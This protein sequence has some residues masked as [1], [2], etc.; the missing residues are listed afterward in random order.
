MKRPR[1]AIRSR[2]SAAVFRNSNTG[3]NED[4]RPSTDRSPQ[5]G[6]I[7]WRWCTFSPEAEL[8]GLP[9]AFCLMGGCDEV[10]RARVPPVGSVQSQP[11]Q[12]SMWLWYVLAA[13]AGA[14]TG[15]LAWM[16]VGV[17]ARPVH[18]R[19]WLFVFAALGVLASLT[20]AGLV[21]AVAHVWGSVFS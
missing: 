14:W 6:A 11:L 15:W 21:A 19:S 3:R 10:A 8:W 20:T 9:L 5:R 1:V 4:I 12:L 18:S 2:G 17:V 16:L 7:A 13:V